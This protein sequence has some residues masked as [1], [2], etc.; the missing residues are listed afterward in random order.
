MMAARSS[1]LWTRVAMPL[2]GTRLSGS[3]SHSFSVSSF[4]SIL[5]CFSASEYSNEGTEAAAR[6]YTPRRR[7]PS[8]SLSSEWHPA[9]RVSNSCFPLGLVWAD[10]ITIATTAPI[11][12]T[13]LNCRIGYGSG[14]GQRIV[15]DR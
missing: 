14:L 10:K 9:Q 4:H 8:L 13:Y 11:A 5:A 6:P 3:V 1:A 7:G 12:A 2:P 15:Y